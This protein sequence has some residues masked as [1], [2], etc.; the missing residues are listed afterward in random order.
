MP[1]W[2]GPL[3]AE[4]AVQPSPHVQLLV[5]HPRVLEYR[6]ERTMQSRIN[7]L[8]DIG[9]AEADIPKVVVRAPVVFACHVERTLRPRIKYL[10]EVSVIRVARLISIANRVTTLN[11]PSR[12]PKPL[13]PV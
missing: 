9:V 12:N 6:V 11:M 8:K 3:K 7:F 13:H 1:V 2:H 5:A 10:M 4:V